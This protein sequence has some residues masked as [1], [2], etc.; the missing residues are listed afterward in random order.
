MLE[1]L[2]KKFK[3]VATYDTFIKI[4][5]KLFV[6]EMNFWPYGEDYTKYKVWFEL[7]YPYNVINFD[8]LLNQISKIFPS[9]F[10]ILIHNAFNETIISFPKLYITDEDKELVK[11]CSI[12]TELF[13]NRP[14]E[15]IDLLSIFEATCYEGE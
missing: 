5:Y 9:N 15:I 1:N 2:F 11:L 12:W 6:L 8:A 10:K 7:T 3:S 14:Q 13:T 4:T